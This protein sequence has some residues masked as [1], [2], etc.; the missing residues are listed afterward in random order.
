VLNIRPVEE[1]ELDALLLLYRHLHATDEM[2]TPDVAKQVWHELR[3]SLRYRYLGAFANG[4]LVSSC[5]LTVIPNLTRG[6]RPYGVIENVVTHPS[7]RRQGLGRRL[8][9][10]ALSFAWSERC[11]KVMLATG[12]R[13]EAVSRFYAS[14][15]FLLHEKQA[16]VARPGA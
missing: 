4:E 13:D 2:P 3:S 16:F 6:G 5:A 15:G 10:E 9:Q 12:R 1:S 14:A 8:L 11:Y 7:H